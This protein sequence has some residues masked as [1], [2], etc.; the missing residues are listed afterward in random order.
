M[1]NNIIFTLLIAALA[2]PVTN[3]EA[4]D[5]DESGWYT[6][7]YDIMSEETYNEIIR[8]AADG[9]YDGAISLATAGMVSMG[10]YDTLIGYNQEQQ[11]TISELYME[12]ADY[13]QNY[14]P[15]AELDAF[16]ESIKSAD[17]AVTEAADGYASFYEMMSEETY[18]EIIRRAATGEYDGAISLATAGM[19]PMVRYDALMSNIKEAQ[20]TIEELELK[21]VEDSE[22]M[23]PKADFETVVAEA[24]DGMYTQ[25]ELEN[26]VAEAVEIAVA[27]AIEGMY[28]QEEYDT[29]VAEAVE[30][31]AAYEYEE[32]P[33]SL[34]AH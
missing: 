12:L 34:P 16:I 18:Y 5:G 13:K 6:D 9:D 4:A 32:E 7:F 33:D 1:T 10:Q 21:L 20:D 2:L 8:R 31:E 27:E 19:V 22:N 23:V 29:A 26:A 25:E 17:D 24:T 15:K 14:V 30:I 3:T 28:T 11:D